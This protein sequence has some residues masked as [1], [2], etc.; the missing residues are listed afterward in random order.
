MVVTIVAFP[1]SVPDQGSLPFTPKL[2]QFCDNI[3]SKQD[4]KGI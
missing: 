4:K 2:M 1:I 3:E